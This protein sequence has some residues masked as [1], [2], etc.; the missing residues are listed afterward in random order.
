MGFLV[1][2]QNFANHT[3]FSATSETWDARPALPRPGKWLPRPQKC[4]E[5]NCYP[6]PKQKNGCP[7]HPCLRP[8]QIMKA[9]Y[10]ELKLA[11]V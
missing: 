3:L 2:R 5:F 8:C 10:S 4:P 6:A 11:I 1:T 9:M 7:V